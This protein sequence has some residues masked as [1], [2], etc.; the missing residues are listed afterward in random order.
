[1]AWKGVAGNGD[2]MNK[3][4]VGFIA[5]SAL[6]FAIIA[7]LVF[8]VPVTDGKGNKVTS[9]NTQSALS[10]KVVQESQL[11]AMVKGSIY[12]TGEIVSVYGSCLDAHDE[13][14]AG[15]NGTLSAWYPNGTKFFSDVAM[16]EIQTGYFLYTGAMSPV[17][18]TYLTEFTCN[19]SGVTAKAFGEWQ[20]PFWV[21]KINQTLDAVQ[22][23]NE[24]VSAINTTNV[25]DALNNLSIVLNSNTATLGDLNTTMQNTYVTLQGVNVSVQAVLD[26][27]RNAN[28]TLTQVLTDTSCLSGRALPIYLVFTPNATP[29]TN[30]ADASVPQVFYTLL[31]LNQS[32]EYTLYQLNLTNQ[33]L[34]SLSAN[35]TLLQ[36]NLTQLSENTSA[37]F[38]LTYTV[39]N[40]T[41]GN[42]TNVIYYA[43]GVANSSVDRN[44]SYLAQLLQLLA[45]TTGAPIN[46]TLTVST[47]AERPVYYKE[48]NV[49][50]TVTNEYGVKVGSP[51]VSCFINTTNTPPTTNGLMSWNAGQERFTYHEK[52]KL[53]GNFTWSVGCVYN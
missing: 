43:A 32:I 26:A 47:S 11:R 1:M 49:N 53:L 4:W 5:A 35:V 10:G 46:H 48:W 2:A 23:L 36:Q 42:V 28:T 25:L 17:Q 51:L 8:G 30:C 12:E 19:D 22:K 3:E 44:D 27:I 21:S 38:N 18:G 50:T 6:L 45:A 16:T 29:S 24:T 34:D 9:D 31:S 13:G 14:I 7:V 41:M 52:V 20:N 39:I 33:K 37:W 15:A 40:Q